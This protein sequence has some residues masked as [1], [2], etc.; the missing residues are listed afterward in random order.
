VI[1]QLIDAATGLH[2]WAERYQRELDDIFTVQDEITHKIVVELQVKLVTGE[3]SR[4]LAKG[5]NSIEAW[6]LVRRSAPLTEVHVRDDAMLA[7]QLLGRALEL[8][9]NYSAAWALL[10]WVHWEESVWEWGSEPEKSMHMAFEAAQKSVSLD[11]NHP[12]GYSL[13]GHIFMERG[14]T[15]QAISMCEKAVELALGDSEAI[16]LLANMLISSGRV[17]EGNLKIQKALRLC[18][19]P[20]PWYLALSG[21]GFHLDGDNE[22]AITALEQAIEREPDSNLARPWLASTL[23]EMGRLDEARVVS[24]AA[25]DIDPTF[26]TMGWTKMF[27]A[28]SHARLKNNLLVAGF[29]E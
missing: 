23:V 25:L 5:T 21:V 18:P 4:S 17:K 26:S 1:A 24:K 29:P 16:G 11:E 7:K 20:S 15:D 14:D 13:L 2:L 12:D 10:G 9:E 8:D 27:K 28:K 22:A 6:E 19:V 3:Y